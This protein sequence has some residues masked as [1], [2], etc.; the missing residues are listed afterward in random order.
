[1]A[2]LATHGLSLSGSG[3]VVV[4]KALASAPRLIETSLGPLKLENLFTLDDFELS[5]EDYANSIDDPALAWAGRAWADC[6]PLGA[7]VQR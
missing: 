2:L 5:F 6:A 7:R 4:R 1:M 3:Y